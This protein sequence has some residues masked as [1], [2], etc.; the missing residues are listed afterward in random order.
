MQSRNQAK[1]SLALFP[2]GQSATFNNSGPPRNSSNLYFVTGRVQLVISTKILY[3][4]RSLSCVEII[5]FQHEVRTILLLLLSDPF[6]YLVPK[7]IQLFT[8]FIA[9]HAA[10]AAVT[11]NSRSGFLC[12]TA[13]L[14]EV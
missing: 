11:I 10:L 14:F 2:C 12:E 5:S 8:V 3:S 9:R 6:H 13:D 4:S 7:E 1:A